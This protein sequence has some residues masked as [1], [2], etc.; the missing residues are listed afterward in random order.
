MGVVP[1]SIVRLY[2]GA[3]SIISSLCLFS[4][5]YISCRYAHDDDTA[6]GEGFA[7]KGYRM[8][9]ALLGQ[10]SLNAFENEP[11]FQV[12]Y[13]RVGGGWMVSFAREAKDV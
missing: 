7:S 1:V 11:A 8:P 3:L 4:E 13:A 5:E 2:R 6:D 12:R 10:S 9:R